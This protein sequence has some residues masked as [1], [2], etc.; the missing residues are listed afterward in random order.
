MANDS[1]KKRKVL[2]IEKNLTEKGLMVTVDHLNQ[3]VLAL[4]DGIRE[5]Q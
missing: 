3:E 4:L 1:Q 2:K 5:N